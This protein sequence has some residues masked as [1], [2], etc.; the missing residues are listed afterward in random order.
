MHDHQE[1]LALARVSGD[2]WG[3][4]HALNALGLDAAKLGDYAGSRRRYEESLDLARDLGDQRMVARI[5][6]YLGYML[7]RADQPAEAEP[8]LQES[9][10]LAMDLGDQGLIPYVLGSLGQAAYTRGDYA[11]AEARSQDSLEQAE[12]LGDRMLMTYNLQRLGETATAQGTYR[13]AGYYFR[14][15]LRTAMEIAALPRALAALIGLAEVQAQA[16][17]GNRLAA[18]GLVAHPLR[19]PATEQTDRHHAERLLAA[20]TAEWGTE[21]V[22]AA[23]QRGQAQP[24]LAVVEDVL[25]TRLPQSLADLL[26]PPEFAVILDVQQ[27]ARQ[28]EE[29]TETDFFA[30]LR[31]RAAALRSEFSDDLDSPSPDQPGGL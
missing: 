26:Q 12:A 23:Q 13:V 10:T 1:S 3:V 6:N 20:L 15:G 2:P 31:A 17:T 25:G 19:H 9:L 30:E 21:A 7:C 14:Q 24:L 8:L 27:Q 4:M 11:E 29:I 28:V 18:A 5:L 22:A 16:Q